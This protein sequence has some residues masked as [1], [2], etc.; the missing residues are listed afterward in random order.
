MSPPQKPH[1]ILLDKCHAEPVVGK[2]QQFQ[3]LELRI[4]EL[5]TSI[6]G[7]YMALRNIAARPEIGSFSLGTTLNEDPVLGSSDYS[8]S[9]QCLEDNT[10]SS[11]LSS[12]TFLRYLEWLNTTTAFEYTEDP[13]SSDEECH[14]KID[15]GYVVV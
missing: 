13:C 14:R 9:T 8:S 6:D 7:A 15:E 2:Y 12:P 4:R 5:E 10:P 11:G 1:P 3:A